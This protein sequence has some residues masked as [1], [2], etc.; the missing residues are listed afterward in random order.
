MSQQNILTTAVH[1]KFVTL[2]GEELIFAQ[3]KHWSVFAFP[4]G[5]FI[6]IASLTFIVSLAAYPLFSAYFSLITAG[7]CLMVAFILSLAVRSV[8]DWYFNIYVVTNRKILEISYSPLSSHKIYEVLLDQVKC[9]E[10]DVKIEGF[11]NDLLD[12]G[13]V[14]VTFDRPT[15]QEEFVFDYME[16]PRAL[17]S[18]LQN[19]FL[20]RNKSQVI[21]LEDP[22]NNRVRIYN[23]NKNYPGKWTYMEEL[24]SLTGAV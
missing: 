10:I 13:H 14:I 2:P 23:R 11:I 18:F 3:R 5:V 20:N 22:D 8:I 16:N 6:F 15:H 1:E 4:L 7:L 21:R 12:V 17:E 9:T 19:N 24:G